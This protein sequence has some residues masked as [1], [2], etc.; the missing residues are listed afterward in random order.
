MFKKTIALL[1]CLAL[2]SLLPAAFA[3]EEKVLNVFTWELYI[4]DASIAQFES[5]TGIKVNYTNF[6]TNEEMLIKLQSVQGG[7]YD[8]IIA[9]DYILNI[10]RKEGL[11]QKLN[12]DM[13]P[14]YKNLDPAT[15]SQYYDE[16][17]EYTVP[18]IVGTPLIVYDPA[19]VDFEITGYEDL[20]NEEL[21]DSVVVMDD[22]RN[23]IGITLKTMGQSFNVT[24]DA[25]LAE[26]K[27]KLAA[28][29]PNIRVFNS[30]TPHQ[31]IL[32]GECAAGYMFTPYVVMALQENP[33][34][35]VVFPKEGLGIGI[36][37]MV[38]P[39][40]APH[41]ENA[42]K[43]INFLL[44]AKVGAHVVEEQLFTTPNAAAHE[45][46]SDELRNNPVLNIDAELLEDAEFIKDLGDYESVY[47]EIWKNFK[48]L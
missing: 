5:E 25:V 12:K 45:Y 6:N 7:E 39:V 28:L 14:N 41:P 23:I 1:L 35:K 32:S 11:L 24:D 37:S 43:M 38:I 17:N 46:L 42:H 21:R 3:Q 4:D 9:S 10:A 33:D 44:D 13:L 34:L 36:D 15:L 27:E 47:Q 48:L 26:A 2:L 19:Q 8:L 18:Y 30:D 40:N 31:D 22:A 16:N 29:R 20:W